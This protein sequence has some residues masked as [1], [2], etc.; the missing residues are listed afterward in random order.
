[1]KELVGKVDF[2]CGASDG[3]KFKGFV[4]RSPNRFTRE[5][6]G[7]L[8]LSLLRNAERSPVSRPVDPK[9]LA[10]SHSTKSRTG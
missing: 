9:K 1:M 7:E 6:D 2:Y 8:L 10:P 3:G 5:S 4:R